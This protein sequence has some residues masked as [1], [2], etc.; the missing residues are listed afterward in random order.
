MINF[1][2]R[3]TEFLKEQKRTTD[4]RRL[5]MLNRDKRTSSDTSKFLLTSP[6]KSC[7][8]Y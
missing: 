8:I 4:K 6:L 5:E 3:F 1:E 2:E 7:I